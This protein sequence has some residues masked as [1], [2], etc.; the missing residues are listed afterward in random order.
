MKRAQAVAIA[1][2]WPR[3]AARGTV[4]LDYDA[5]HRRRVMLTSDGGEE[6]LLDLPR[7][8]A[9]GD[10]DALAL[11]DGGWIEVKAA[12]EPLVEIRGGAE[13]LSRA[14]WHLGNRH[15][16]AAI[17]ADRIL[18]REDHVIAEMLAG[19]GAALRS[20]TAPFTPERGAY[21]AGALPHQHDHRHNH[22][23]HHD[24]DDAHHNQ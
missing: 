13:L 16:P 23:H 12:P 18:I 22:H 15:L 5:R 19:L 17:F 11:G 7:A 10:G 21:D 4:T 14:A 3:A 8:V 6:F 1:G 9:L 24:D 20:L 2:Q